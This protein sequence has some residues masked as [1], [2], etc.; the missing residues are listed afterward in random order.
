MTEN[1]PHHLKASGML[2]LNDNTLC[3][4]DFPQ[5]MGVL[6]RRFCNQAVDPYH[7]FPLKVRTQTMGP[8]LR[9]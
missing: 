1:P 5:T 7:L 9:D 4:V 8:S 3:Y 2:E 6:M